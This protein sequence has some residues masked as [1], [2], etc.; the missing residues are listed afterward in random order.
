MLSLSP[1]LS[2][3]LVS[4]QVDGREYMETNEGLYAALRK[5]NRAGVVLLENVGVAEKTVLLSLIHI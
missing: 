5:M 3:S 1:S 4:S 2:L